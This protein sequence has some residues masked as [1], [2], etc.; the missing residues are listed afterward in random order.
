MSITNITTARSRLAQ[1]HAEY[2]AGIA[3]VIAAEV[4]ERGWDGEEGDL[5]DLTAIEITQMI[6]NAF[7][8]GSPMHELMHVG[9]ARGCI[10]TQG[11]YRQWAE[12]SN[13]LLSLGKT[14]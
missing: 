2:M 9:L 12:E 3:N 8:N 10:T 5:K 11:K 1:R 7:P 6:D 14:A 4:E 13:Y